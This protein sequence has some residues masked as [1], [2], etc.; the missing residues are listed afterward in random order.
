MGVSSIGRPVHQP[1]ACRPER[2]PIANSRKKA[3]KLNSFE[4]SL[5]LLS[6]SKS[7]EGS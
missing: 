5:S 4:T 2:I 6:S 7:S 3:L 1:E